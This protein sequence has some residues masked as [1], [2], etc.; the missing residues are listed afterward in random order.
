ML[1]LDH[2][3]IRS[4]SWI[5]KLLHSHLGFY[6]KLIF[7]ADNSKILVESFKKTDRIL[8]Q[9]AVPLY[10]HFFHI[11]DISH[12]SYIPDKKLKMKAKV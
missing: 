11:V 7:L 12:L 6:Q 1:I 3:S 8:V 2:N 5:L 10:F 4:L 9:K